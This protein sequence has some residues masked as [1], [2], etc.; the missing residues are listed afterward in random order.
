MAICLLGGFGAT[1][2]QQRQASAKWFEKNKPEMPRVTTSTRWAKVIS[3]FEQAA[4]D[5]TE[6]RR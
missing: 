3:T 1:A 4:I 2:R 5:P 6:E